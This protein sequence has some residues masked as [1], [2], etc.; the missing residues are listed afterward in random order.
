MPGYDSVE[1]S[2]GWSYR[3]SC[4]P[5]GVV[6]LGVEEVEAAS[7]IHEDVRQAGLTNDW[8]YDEGEVPGCGMWLG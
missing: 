7:T 3:C 4:H 8:F 6:R 2:T 5:H 1:Q